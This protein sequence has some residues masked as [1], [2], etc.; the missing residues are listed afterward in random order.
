MATVRVKNAHGSIVIGGNVS[1]SQVNNSAA[2]ADADIFTQLRTAIDAVQDGG[3]RQKLQ[4][5]AD[6]MESQSGQAGFV[7]KYKDFMQAAANHMTLF[8]PLLPALT[9]LMV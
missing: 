7:Q 9:A 5:L 2:P 1:R 6:A 4:R 3:E 8:A